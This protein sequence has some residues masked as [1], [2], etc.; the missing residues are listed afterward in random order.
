M[1]NRN[2]INVR[3][4]SAS[5]EFRT[6]VWRSE[7][8]NI[9][10]FLFRWD[11]V[12]RHARFGCKLCA[13]RHLYVPQFYKLSRILAP[14]IAKFG[15]WARPEC[16]TSRTR[17][18]NVFGVFLSWKVYLI[19]CGLARHISF[20]FCDGLFHNQRKSLWKVCNKLEFKNA[21]YWM[22]DV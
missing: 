22:L 17:K 7:P 12:I 1:E 5:V 21:D 10:S 15:D 4:A 3:C 2:E 13:Q 6:D 18:N 11:A 14:V 19:K 16:G 20:C 9:S 8:L